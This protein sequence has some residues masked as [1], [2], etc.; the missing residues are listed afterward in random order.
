MSQLDD[1]IAR[2]MASENQPSGLDGLIARDEAMGGAQGA[3]S[4]APSHQSEA[5]MWD[6]T[7]RQLGL[8]A[9]AG[10]TGVA[11]LPTMVGNALN[12]ATNF[13]I[14]GI[15]H[16][17]GAHLP[18]FDMPSAALD[19]GL[20][21]AGLPRPG[22]R[23][24]RVVQDMA[25]AMA[26]VAPSMAAG[27]TLAAAA[28]P[29]TSAVGR[30]LQALPGMQLLGAA[31]SGAGG[32]IARESGVGP[33][34][35]LAA[36]VLGGGVAAGAPS[37][38]LAVARPAARGA[39]TVASNVKGV[40]QP[41]TNPKD[42][43]GQ[44][45]ASTLGPDAAQVAQ[46]IRG[47]DQFVP[48]SLPT[49][50]QVG[51]TPTLVATEK[52]LAN[53][54]PEFKLSFAQ[55]HADNNAARWKVLDGIAQTPEALEQAKAARQAAVSPLY[56]AAH[57]NTANVGPA[58]NRYAQ[59]PEMQ[60]AMAVANENAG[61]DSAVGRGVAPVWPGAQS[62]SING[63]A[64]DYTSRALDD[65]ISKAKMSGDS[66]RAASLLALQGKLDNWTQTY[67]PGVKQASDAYANLS[68][69]ISTM[70]AGQHIAGN[71]GTR[72]MGA[73]GIADIQ[74]MPYRSALTQA[75][76][77]QRFGID[78]QAHASLQGIGQDLQRA[79][80][81]NSLRS[82][83][84]D[85]AYNIA[86]NGWLARQ[87]Y[88]PNFEGTG[89][90]AKGIGALGALASGSPTLA[91]GVLFG[92]KKLGTMTANHLN[93][94]LGNFML[95]PEQLLPYLNATQPS[96]NRAAQAL[97]ARGYVNQGLLGA[98]ISPRSKP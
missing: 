13:G 16:A 48:G 40:L 41:L 68:T 14:R 61:L 90:V 15:N 64:L 33:I 28:S 9:R 94:Q 35:Q 87:L 75:L 56:E 22:N 71:L 59:I 39:A 88:G 97:G 11:G 26:G 38:G 25:S 18:E 45:L 31:G 55:R 54:S 27:R 98:F 50:A 82:P 4:V 70:E 7:A 1:L 57:Q 36:S 30:T 76:K 79:T 89:N 92:G 63:A 67:I 81:S 5:S 37:A 12:T 62:K 96:A 21:A 8:T 91:A 83:G 53:V 34:G 58:F 24:E 19:Q 47:A 95:N 74:L 42:Y 69:P 17:T 85:T 80:V 72:A 77:S 44:Q 29:V 51:G 23:T 3:S 78:P 86:A 20:N 84:S 73:D 32:G 43:V 6:Q 65:M 60:A 49:T 66:S 10:V 2:D 46:R 93:T 52:A